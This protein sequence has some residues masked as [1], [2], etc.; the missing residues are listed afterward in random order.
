MVVGY[1]AYAQYDVLLS[2]RQCQESKLACKGL[3]ATIFIRRKH[4]AKMQKTKVLMR[5]HCAP[6]IRSEES[7]RR[8]EQ[9]YT[10]SLWSWDISLTLNMT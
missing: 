8:T 7:H 4:F 6:Y 10:L 1:F 3:R 9:T 2:L 5:Q